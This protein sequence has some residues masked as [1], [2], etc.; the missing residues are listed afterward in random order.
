VS[1]LNKY[2]V[3]GSYHAPPEHTLFFILEADR[4]EKIIDFMKPLMTLGTANIVPV[5]PLGDVVEKWLDV[6]GFLSVNE[7]S[8]K[9]W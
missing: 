4:Y 1:E 6:L 2:N 9:K 3:F 7:N 5:S 8:E